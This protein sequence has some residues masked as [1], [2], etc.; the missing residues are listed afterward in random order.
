MCI[1]DRFKRVENNINLADMENEISNYWDEIDAF[2][3]SLNNRNNDKVFR[4][5][6]GPPFPN[7]KSSLWKP[8]SWCN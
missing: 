5:Y 3:T 1:R 8:F 6:D 7:R 4:F 2:Q